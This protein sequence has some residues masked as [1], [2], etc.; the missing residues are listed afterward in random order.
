MPVVRLE[1]YGANRIL[2]N[3]PWLGGEGKDL[4]KS[5][6]GCAPLW[7]KSGEKD[8]W[9]GWTYPLDLEVCRNLRVV[10]GDM[11]RIGPELEA[12]A[13]AEVATESA[14]HALRA[15][16]EHDLPGIEETAPRLAQAFRARPYQPVAVQ[17]ALDGKRV[18]I[19]DEP[20]LGKTLET[21]GTLALAGCRRVLVVAKK[22]A[23][24]AVWEREIRRWLPDA[25]PFAGVPDRGDHK[26][27]REA[28]IE[29]FDTFCDLAPDKL[30]ILI[31]NPEMMRIKFTPGSEGSKRVEI[32]E[33]PALF[34]RDWDAIVFDESHRI[35]IG[36]NVQSKSITQT[37]LGSIRLPLN[38]GGYKIAL[39]GTPFRGKEVN[40]WGTL[41]WL[42][43]DTHTSYWKFAERY[44]S[45]ADNDY[46]G[47]DIINEG[48]IRPDA[49]EAFDRMLARYMIRR[50]KFEVARDLPPKMYGGALLN[51]ADPKSPVGVWLPLTPSQRML[52]EQ[53]SDD[54]TVELEHGTLMINGVLAEL[55]RQKQ[56]ATASGD[57][58]EDYRYRPQLP[59]NKLDWILDFLEETWGAQGKII[60]ASQFTQVVELFH[61]QCTKAGYKCHM[62]TG[63]TSQAK[64]GEVVLDFSNL[65]SEYRCC[66]INT[67]AGGES[68]TLDAADYVVVIDETHIPDDQIQLED[69]AHRVSREAGRPPV[70]VYYLRSLGTVD[71]E[72]PVITGA[73]EGAIT[74]R[75]DGSR[76][77]EIL[78]KSARLVASGR[79]LE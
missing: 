3:V 4:A 65:A 22:T 34:N 8:K 59:S 62:I 45:V 76:G 51:P 41:N 23:I 25:E 79:M 17:F 63:K 15:S 44:F 27:A 37:R 70:T 18:I 32:P 47:K 77:I 35:V 2:A 24:S 30:A 1:R 38:G 61:G 67:L 14:Q 72:I 7:D 57:F 28:I 66:F 56:V 39:S 6:A 60:I 75:L 26:L 40:I 12:W 53:I 69:R 54:A 64:R 68:I 31:V 33:F 20:G 49:R 48:R 19:A 9:I 5:V 58:D 50:T 78:A 10:F 42:W 52:Y 73:R 71:E 43:P 46:G 11:L 29:S 16:Y 74:E 36:K 55:T 21:L 13:K